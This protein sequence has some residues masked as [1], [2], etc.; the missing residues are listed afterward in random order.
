MFLRWSLTLSPRL[1][2]SDMILAHSNLSAFWVPVD[3]AQLIFVFLV[4]TGFHYVGRAC[5]KLLTSSDPL[6][7]ASQ[8][9]GITGVSHHTWPVS[10]FI[11]SERE[12]VTASKQDV[13]LCTG[14]ETEARHGSMPCP[15]SHSKA[16]ADQALNGDLEVN[17]V[18]LEARVTPE[19]L[20]CRD[21]AGDSPPAPAS[22][23]T[24]RPA[25][26]G[27]A[28]VGLWKNT[29]KCLALLP[30]L[31]CSGTISAHC[32]LRLLGSK[33]FSCLSL[34]RMGFHH[35]GQAGLELLTSGDPPALA[36]QST[37]II[38]GLALSSRLECSGGIMA[39]CSLNLLGSE[40]AS[41]CVAQAGLKLLSPSPTPTSASQS[42]GITSMSHPAWPRN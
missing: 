40:M 26:Q 14:E 28:A 17:M 10:E 21:K 34:W 32:N 4:E 1:E 7:L 22:F 19:G 38:G 2:C 3:H 42:T 24:P 41:H 9:A 35:V 16:G 31:E 20:T 33:R 37:G 11:L 18:L 15:S 23:Q 30:R 13:M 39:P 6:T 25:G 36:S 29:E 27:L 5:L 8:S 12:P